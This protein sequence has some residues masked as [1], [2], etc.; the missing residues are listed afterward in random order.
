MDTQKLRELAESA[1]E[2]AMRCHKKF[3]AESNDATKAG[4]LN[5]YFYW[6]GHAVAYKGV[7]AMIELA[8]VV[9]DERDATP[10]C[11]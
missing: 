3:Q 10:T 6:A 4:Y 2:R 5:D 11:P 8:T 1:D 9:E 7:V